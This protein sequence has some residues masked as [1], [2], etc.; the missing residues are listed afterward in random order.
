MFPW[1]T[2]TLKKLILPHMPNLRFMNLILGS[3]LN[4]LFIELCVE[5]M[6]TS[7]DHTPSQWQIIQSPSY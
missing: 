6:H 1:L 3:L 4:I 5:F 7:T 2:K